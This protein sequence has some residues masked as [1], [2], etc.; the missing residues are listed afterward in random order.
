M[1]GDIAFAAMA[2]LVESGP[3]GRIRLSA[4]GRTCMIDHLEIWRSW[5]AEARLALANLSLPLSS[6][7]A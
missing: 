2:G 3:E 4:D 6:R 1:D 5:S 7:A